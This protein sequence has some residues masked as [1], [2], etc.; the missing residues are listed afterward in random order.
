MSLACGRSL[1]TNSPIWIT[2]KRSDSAAQLNFSNH[3]DDPQLL[4]ALRLRHALAAVMTA[5]EEIHADISTK[6][7]EG[8]VA[9]YGKKS[10][11]WLLLVFCSPHAPRVHACCASNLREEEALRPMLQKAQEKSAE[12]FALEN[13]AKR[14]VY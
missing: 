4:P 13:R 10:L 7:S 6:Y 12:S 9:G 1:R 14:G 8:V 2:R 5:L 3:R 11:G